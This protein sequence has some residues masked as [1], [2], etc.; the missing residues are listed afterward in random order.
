MELSSG[1]SKISVVITNFNKGYLLHRAVKSVAQQSVAPAELVIVDDCSD[2]KDAIAALNSIPPTP[3]ESRVV[4]SKKR[5]GAAGA[6][7]LGV[8]SS[9]HEVIML[10]DA[11]DELPRDAVRDITEFLA[12]NP[13]ADFVFGDVLR[14]RD[15]HQLLMRGDAFSKTDGTLDPR[16]LAKNWELHGTTPFRK[17]FF[18]S[19]GGFDNLNPRTDDSDFFRRGIL[20]GGVGIYIPCHIYTTHLDAS[21]NSRG[22]DP[23]TLSFSWFRN[24]DFYYFALPGWE[25]LV[26]LARKSKAARNTRATCKFMI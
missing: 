7:N 22:I 11:D 18:M 20:H 5:K 9:S 8:R 17:E 21:E 3:F 1:T 14:I 6:K 26:L 12:K 2:E 23:L 13:G 10:L 25:F 24:I 19:I 16:K 15:G 4:K